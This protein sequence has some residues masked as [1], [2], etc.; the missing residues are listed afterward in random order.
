MAREALNRLTYWLLVKK[1][2]EMGLDP[3]YIDKS[4]TYYENLEE[5]QRLIHPRLKDVVNRYG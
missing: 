1:C 4:L 2:R 5:L 3:A